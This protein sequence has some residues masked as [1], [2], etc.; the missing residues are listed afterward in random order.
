MNVLELFIKYIFI[1][2]AHIELS[3]FMSTPSHSVH[4]TAMHV[5]AFAVIF[6]IVLW[7][8]TE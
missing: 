3:Y 1:G 8:C 7:P 2:K 6:Y 4:V 5:C